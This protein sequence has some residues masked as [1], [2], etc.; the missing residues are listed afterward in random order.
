MS[1]HAVPP[2]GAGF[3]LSEPRTRFIALFGLGT[4]AALVAIILGLQAY[5]DHV[6]Q[7][8]IFER[9][10]QPVAEDLRALYAREDT[11]LNSYAYI[12]RGKGTVR[13]PIARA[14]ELLSEEYAQ[15]RLPYS[16][17][18]VPVKSTEM[19]PPPAAPA[20]GAAK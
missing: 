15:E 10:L 5:V 14:M 19:P 11:E 18:P 2:P 20:K 17:K 16:T 8:E 6:E 4:L 1:D 7:Q 3:D 12:D 9:V 13:L